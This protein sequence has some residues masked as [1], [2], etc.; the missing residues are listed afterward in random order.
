VKP[1]TARIKYGH[2]PINYVCIGKYF[3]T[4]IPFVQEL[5]RAV[6]K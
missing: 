5:K 3:L 2:Y 1:E 6:D 4:V